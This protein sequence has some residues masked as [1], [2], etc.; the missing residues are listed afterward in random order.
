MEVKVDPDFLGNVTIC[1]LEV[2]WYLHVIELWYSTNNR[3][4]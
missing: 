1:V 3:V 2:V 4:L